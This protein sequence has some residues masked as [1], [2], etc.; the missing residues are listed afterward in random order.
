MFWN[1]AKD[2]KVQLVQAS[3]EFLPLKKTQKNPQA[4][5]ATKPHT[6]SK[7]PKP[8]KNLQQATK[9]HKMEPRFALKC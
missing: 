2:I 8:P 7:N 1:N 3:H 4:Q 5:I 6:P 9:L